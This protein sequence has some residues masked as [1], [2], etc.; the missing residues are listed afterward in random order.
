M[1][2]E[3]PER[4]D[5]AIGHWLFDVRNSAERDEIMYNMTKHGIKVTTLH[6]VEAAMAAL[7]TIPPDMWPDGS[8]D[9]QE[10]LYE[11]AGAA[12]A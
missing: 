4:D 6:A 3:A 11:L 1:G 2:V 8:V 5:A 9:Q 7:K 10:P 12:G